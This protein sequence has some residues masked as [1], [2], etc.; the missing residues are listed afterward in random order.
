MGSSSEEKLSL[1]IQ[2][3]ERLVYGKEGVEERFYTLLAITY[4]DRLYKFKGK[5]MPK[6]TSKALLAA[7]PEM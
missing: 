3:L 7:N 6:T 5:E 2:Y 4:A 1:K